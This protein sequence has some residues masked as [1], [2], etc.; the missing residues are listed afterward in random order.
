MVNKIEKQLGWQRMPSA[1]AHLHIHGYTD[2]V[3]W[4]DPLY[5]YG[6]DAPLI[7]QSMNGSA[8]KWISEKL[9]IHKMQVKWAVEHEMARTVED[10]LSRRTRALL[11]DA[12]ESVRISL[13]VATI[14]A[15]L[16]NKD[17]NWIYEQVKLYTQL[18][19]Q[20][21]LKERTLSDLVV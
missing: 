10:V 3:N 11:L 12:A 15:E 9:K 21:I 1:S 17:H 8:G 14:M 16:L 2:N 18:A 4:N 6:S 19:Q 5:F 20:Y 7:M 13:E